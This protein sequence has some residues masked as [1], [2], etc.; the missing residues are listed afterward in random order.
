M[1]F[2]L[3]IVPERSPTCITPSAIESDSR[4]NAKIARKRNCF[5]E[6][7]QFV[8]NSLEPAGDKHLTIVAECNAGR[9]R[10]VAGVLRNVATDIYAEKA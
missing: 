3:K 1:P 7:S 4:R 6:R 2:T 9:V 8:N 10:D 5:F